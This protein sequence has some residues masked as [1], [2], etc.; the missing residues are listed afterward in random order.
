VTD[1]VEGRSGEPAELVGTDPGARDRRVE[2]VAAVMLSIAT[3]VTAWSAYQATRWSGVQAESYVTAS[4]RRT[5]SVRAANRANAQILV[6]VDVYLAWV[7]AVRHGKDVFAADLEDRMR[8][9]FLP[10]FEAWQATEPDVE[11]PDGTP[12]TRP[13]YVL[14]EQEKA[15]QLEAEASASFTDGQEANQTSDNFVLA[16]VLLASVLFFSGLAGTFDAF[17]A[18]VFLLVLAALMLVVG[19]LIVLSLPQDVGY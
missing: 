7:D 11:I 13:E 15:A 17:R 5:E 4:A 16:A 1:P 12:F 3:V 6:D 9:E 14:A 18:Q 19:M 2:M 10:A 8:D